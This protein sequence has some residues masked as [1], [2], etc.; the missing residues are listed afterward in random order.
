MPVLSRLNMLFLLF[1]FTVPIFGVSTSAH[2][3]IVTSS[4]I[5]DAEQMALEREQIRDLLTRE[6]VQQALAAQ[7][8]DVNAAKQRVDSMTNAEVQMLA[9]KMDQLPAG[10]GLSTIELLLIII[11][12][13]LLI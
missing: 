10:A 6:D 13:I 4:Q 5:V 3:G 9:A 2:A 12:I 1:V 8:V 7:G 11:I